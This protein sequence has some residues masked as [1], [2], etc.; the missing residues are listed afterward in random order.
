[1]ARK[2]TIAFTVEGAEIRRYEE[3]YGMTPGSP[4]AVQPDAP[5]GNLN[6][7]REGI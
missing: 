5:G 7:A 2:K 6:G 3:T 4:K 1:M